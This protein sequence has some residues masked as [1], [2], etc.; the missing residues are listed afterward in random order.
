M[1]LDLETV[2]GYADIAA[3][4]VAAATFAFG[5]WKYFE[6]Q[7]ISQDQS[8]MQNSILHIDRIYSKDNR[9]R[10]LR[11]VETYAPLFETMQQPTAGDIERFHK[12]VVASSPDLASIISDHI[13][14][15]YYIDASALCVQSSNCDEQLLLSR[16]CSDYISISYRT[17]PLLRIIRDQGLS[18]GEHAEGFY[19]Q[20]C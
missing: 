4:I 20:K 15:F 1:P 18:A 7:T 2:R 9:D 13:E 3:K 8:R 17:S 12:F 16:I 6:D 5:V 19:A 10:I 14:L 11:L